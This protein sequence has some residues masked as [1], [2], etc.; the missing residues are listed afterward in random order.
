[1]TE[2]TVDPTG[3]SL[4]SSSMT[5]EESVETV[6]TARAP[7]IYGDQ[8]SLM[9]DVSRLPRADE[10]I[11][12]QASIMDGSL[13]DVPGDLKTVTY[14]VQTETNLGVNDALQSFADPS[15]ISGYTSGLVRRQLDR[16]IIAYAEETA[17]T[18][19]L[20]ATGDLVAPEV[21]A[22]EFSYFDGVEWLL[23]WDSSSQSL[24]W[25]IQ[26]SLA[27]QSASASEDVYLEPGTPISTMPYADRQAYGIEV[28]ELVVAIPGAQITAGAAMSEDQAA[29][30]DSLGL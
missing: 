17:D 4:A 11:I 18:Q 3:S 16:A 29:G 1:M 19:R 2:E 27:M 13:T 12:Q 28:Y 5:S 15:Q 22:L 20:M 21:I 8:Y 24:P 25:L 9:V 23:Q 30:M 14:Y 6:V 10:Y 26:I 7:G